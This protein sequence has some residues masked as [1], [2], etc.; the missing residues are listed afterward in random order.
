MNDRVI[1]CRPGDP[2]CGKVWD[3]AGG[4]E[5]TTGGPLFIVIGSETPDSKCSKLAERFGLEARELIE[6]RDAA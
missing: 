1:L 2:R 5:Q 3:E 4:F 6:Y